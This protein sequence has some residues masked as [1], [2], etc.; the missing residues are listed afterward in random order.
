MTSRFS[1]GQP[2][3]AGPG[4]IRTRTSYFHNYGEYHETWRLRIQFPL[5]SATSKY[6]CGT[7]IAGRAVAICGLLIECV[8]PTRRYATDRL[9]AAGDSCLSTL[10]IQHKPICQLQC[11]NVRRLFLCCADT[12]GVSIHA[13]PEHSFTRRDFRHINLQLCWHI[14]QQTFKTL[15]AVFGVKLK[16]TISGYLCAARGGPYLGSVMATSVYTKLG[17]LS[18]S[19]NGSE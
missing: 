15:A 5:T 10:L 4:G 8:S 11:I 9:L 12:F 14:Y 6:E 19:L 16:R 17:P 2:P 18:R 13:C 3:V 7:S 1:S